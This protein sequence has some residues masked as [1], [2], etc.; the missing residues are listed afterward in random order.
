[1]KRILALVMSLLLSLTLLAGCGDPQ[2]ASDGS[3]D[4]ATSG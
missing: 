4:P 3:K 2:G 1:M